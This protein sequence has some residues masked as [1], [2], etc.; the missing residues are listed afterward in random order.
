[1]SNGHDHPGSY[2]VLVLDPDPTQIQAD[3]D[4][5][6]VLGY[7]LLCI[8]DRLAVFYKDEKK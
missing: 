1:M 6:E 7:N 8:N 5:Q 3:F 2:H 4:A